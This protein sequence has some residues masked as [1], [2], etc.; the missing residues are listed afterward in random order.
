M[1]VFDS[2]NIDSFQNLGEWYSM[3]KK[4]NQNKS[5]AGKFCLKKK[6][7][8]AIGILVSTKNDLKGLRQVEISDAMDAGKKLGFEYFETAA[9]G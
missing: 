5:L 2:T 6:S 1:L 4:A 7:I 9:V 3:V 8:N